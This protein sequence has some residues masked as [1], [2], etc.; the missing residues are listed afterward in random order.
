MLNQ[1]QTRFPTEKPIRANQRERDNRILEHLYNFRV[2][3][4]EQIE[5]MVFQ[6]NSLPTTVANR[7]LLR[8]KHESLVTQIPQPKDKPYRYMPK[9][10]I[11]P[12]SSGRQLHFL[13]IA[14]I[15]LKLFQ[16]LIFVV[17]PDLDCNYCPDAY[18]E[19]DKGQKALIECQRTRISNPK[20]QEKIDKF[21]ATFPKHKVN[22]LLIFYDGVPFDIVTPSG[23]DIRQQKLPPRSY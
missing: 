5:R 15:Y 13:A 21:A 20:M 4:R 9:P 17:E 10:T 2:L 19:T 22:L 11:I 1:P 12:E 3:T 23:F 7:V 8:L 6:N 18:V 16:P 14:D